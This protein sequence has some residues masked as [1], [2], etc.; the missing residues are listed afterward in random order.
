MII[1]WGGLSLPGG[2]ETRAQGRAP[3]RSESWAFR[4][5][6]W[7]CGCSLGLLASSFPIHSPAHG[8]NGPSGTP[9]RLQAFWG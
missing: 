9:A 3:V 1:G 5:Q 8:R 2:L 6:L 7:L 4:S